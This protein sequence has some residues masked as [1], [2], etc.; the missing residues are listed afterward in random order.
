M[1]RLKQPSFFRWAYFF[2][3]ANFILLLSVVYVFS[4]TVDRI[5]AVVNER[6]I[7]LTD[8]RIAEAF[9]LYDEELE[10]KPGSIRAMILERLIDQKLVIDIAG[11]EPLVEKKELDSFQGKIIEKLGYDHFQSKLEEFDLDLEDL[12]GYISEKIVYQKI[13][14]RRF[15]QRITVS[16]KEMEDYYRQSY[17]P[18]QREKGLEPRPMLELLDQI[19]SRIILEKIKTQINDWIKNLRKKADIQK[20]RIDA[21]A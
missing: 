1:S 8:L 13:I 4:E 20:L 12:R 14:S 19:E 3:L 21:G 17:V 5:V 15:G 2:L 10:E 16:V 7:T 11:E 6:V 9:A 18:S